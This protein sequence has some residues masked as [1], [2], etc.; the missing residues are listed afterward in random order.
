MDRVAGR[1]G[2]RTATI[3]PGVSSRSRR[4]SNRSRTTSWSRAPG[5]AEAILSPSPPVVRN[6]LNRERRPPIPPPR[7]GKMSL[8]SLA[9]FVRR[10]EDAPAGPIEG[11]VQSDFSPKPGENEGGSRMGERGLTNLITTN[12]VTFVGLVVVFSMLIGCAAGP[13]PIEAPASFRSNLSEASGTLPEAD[14]FLHLRPSEEVFAVH[15]LDLR[16]GGLEIHLE[17]GR[18]R[19]L[20]LPD[21]REVAG[22]FLGKGSYRYVIDD[23]YDLDLA[24]FN[25]EKAT[26]IDLGKDGAVA[27]T[28]HRALLLGLNQPQIFTL[29]KKEQRDAPSDD[30]GFDRAW[31]E[32]W[33]WIE[34]EIL[35]YAAVLLNEEESPYLEW[36]FDGK[37]ARIQFKF[38]KIW[39]IEES[40]HALWFWKQKYLLGKDETF[41]SVSP[42]VRK[43]IERNRTELPPDPYRVTGL[44]VKMKVAGDLKRYTQTL[45]LT[46]TVDRDRVRAL[47]FSLLNWTPGY[48]N[49]RLIV[50]AIEDE[51]GNTLPFRHF[52]DHLL[53]KLPRTV[54]QGET[55][56]LRLHIEST[57]LRHMEHEDILMLEGN[58][59][60]PTTPGYLV[61][62]FT[63]E[64]EISCPK[65]FR[66]IA[67]GMDQALTESEGEIVLKSRS[68]RKIHS[69]GLGCGKF[70]S[71]E[72]E[73]PPF[74]VRIHTYAFPREQTDQIFNLAHAMLHYYH[75]RFGPPPFTEIDI[76]EIPYSLNYGITP[77]GM[78]L[79][80]SNVFDPHV[81]RRGRIEI[82]S[83]SLGINGLLAHEFAHVWWGHGVIPRS[84]EDRWLAES[85]AE[86]SAYLL[87]RAYEEDARR[88]GV[89][90]SGRML[91]DWRN[92]AKESTDVVPIPRADE[93][94]D[95]DV[96]D[97]EDRYHRVRLIYA[98]GPLFLRYLEEE[99]GRNAMMRA[100][101]SFY[102]RNLGKAVQTKDFV[103][104][105]EEVS[106]KD[107]SPLFDAYFWGK[108]FPEVKGE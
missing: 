72:R 8:P 89:L 93:L 97:D 62:H 108:A 56:R 57:H 60:F 81:Q 43:P 83:Y 27:D 76:V 100:M 2:A 54:S 30:S 59:W 92:R 88:A 16:V 18:F 85:F 11:E 87:M 90:T 49:D 61:D 6:G 104:I 38:D 36:Q 71:S 35:R 45:D 67:S 39:E 84:E 78:L 94:T 79:L 52:R 14:A 33:G 28:F 75:K 96:T 46:V 95:T 7:R 4:T 26:D 70:V 1:S 44:G 82:I 47:L 3:C 48:P 17:E 106:G 105:L 91:H 73:F 65:P 31:K 80:A 74:R 107:L 22:V 19:P 10:G 41:L 20:H 98:K 68:K 50:R 21:G 102:R 9:P 66:P 55:V 101:T 103:A 51:G 40:L 99:V 24:R 29:L 42:I 13:P 53:V 25:L 15:A 34:E 77:A 64:A 63:W 32:G 69:P 86:Y 12:L 37:L 5:G 23:P 58:D